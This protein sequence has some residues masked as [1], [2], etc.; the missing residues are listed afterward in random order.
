MQLW[1]SLYGRCCEDIIGACNTTE[2]K[3]RMFATLGKKQESTGSEGENGKNKKLSRKKEKNNK[4]NKKNKK[5]KKQKHKK[6]KGAS[7]RNHEEL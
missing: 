7:K 6:N 4:N 5:H 1:G 2:V 3:S